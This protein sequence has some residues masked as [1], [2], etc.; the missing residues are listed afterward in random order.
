MTHSLAATH[1][2]VTKQML[3]DD[4]ISRTCPVFGPLTR[5]LVDL[6]PGLQPGHREVHGDGH[7]LQ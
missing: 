6:Q 7:R 3:D 5:R 2:L 4:Y 1:V